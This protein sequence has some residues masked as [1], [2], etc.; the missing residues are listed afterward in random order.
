MLDESVPERQA[1][2][3]SRSRVAMNAERERYGMAAP[4]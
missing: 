1:I 4:W 3:R 2:L